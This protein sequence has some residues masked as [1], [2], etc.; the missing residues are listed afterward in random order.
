M[1]AKSIVEAKAKVVELVVEPATAVE[2]QAMVVPQ[3]MVVVAETRY[4]RR[5][6]NIRRLQVRNK[7]FRRPN[8][9]DH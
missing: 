8:S 4:R 7:R 6:R 9:Q 3:L 2:P 1:V 5:Q